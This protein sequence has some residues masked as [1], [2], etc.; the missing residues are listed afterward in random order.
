MNYPHIKDNVEQIQHR[1]HEAA[2]R[3]GRDADSVQLLPVTKT[4]DLDVVLDLYELGFRA[5]GEN[6]IHIAEAKITQ[7]PSNIHWHMIGSIQRRKVMDVV[8][9]FDRIDSI[10]RLELAQE[11]EKRCAEAEKSV[12][13]LL[14]VNV[15]GEDVKH[16]FS[17]KVLSDT[18]NTVQS[19]PH[20]TVVGLMTMAPQEADESEIRAV[21][22]GLKLLADDN[23]LGVLSMGMTNDFEIAIE[24]GATE[25][26]IGT[27]LFK[28]RE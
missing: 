4:V 26:R 7:A 27:A 15:S 12:E 8:R 25:I 22:S 24:E 1:I 14:Q 23:G 5:M 13:M 21:F 11:L 19:C 16:G 17:P 18:L 2:I 9:L 20:L 28:E 6:R 3:V 10:D